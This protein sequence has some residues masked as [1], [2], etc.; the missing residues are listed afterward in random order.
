MT[1]G[2]RYEQRVMFVSAVSELFGATLLQMM[3]M[4]M[5]AIMMM[6]K[7]NSKC[8]RANEEHAL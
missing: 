4:I 3:V 5:M 1:K 6:M 8:L 7:T 2:S